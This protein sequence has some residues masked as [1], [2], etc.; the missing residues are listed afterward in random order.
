LIMNIMATDTIIIN[1]VIRAIIDDEIT[2]L[3]L[4]IVVILNALS[5]LIGSN[6]LYKKTLFNLL[7]SLI[8]LSTILMIFLFATSLLFLEPLTTNKFF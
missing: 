7:A 5:G 8:E 4:S 3:I 2:P 6:S 1:S